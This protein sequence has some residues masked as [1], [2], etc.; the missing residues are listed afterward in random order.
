[1]TPQE[2]LAQIAAILAVEGPAAPQPWDH[3]EIP[4]SQVT[5][6]DGV[7]I[8]VDGSVWTYALD[9]KTPLGLIYGYISKAKNPPMWER[10][11]TVLGGED[12]LQ[13]IIDQNGHWARYK[14]HPEA[15]LHQ[16]ANSLMLLSMVLSNP[17]P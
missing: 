12:R 4:A 16:G 8:Q 14:A 2:K 6:F 17:L 1:M 10:M 5:A 11:A 9:G 3:P 15:V 7:T 13:A